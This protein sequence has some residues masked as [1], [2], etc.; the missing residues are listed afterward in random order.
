[1][2]ASLNEKISVKD[3]DV[4]SRMKEMEIC[5][6][7]MRERSLNASRHQMVVIKN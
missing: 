6:Q 3:E 7:K 5:M 4:L 1:M 2:I